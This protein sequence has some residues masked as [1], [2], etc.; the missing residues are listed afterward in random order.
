MV[1][2]IL[3][4][5]QIA[6][7][8]RQG[9][10]DQVEALKE[11][12]FIP[13]LS[14]ILVGNDGA[15]QSYVRSKKKAAE[16]I[17]MISEIVHLEETATEE[18]VLNELNRLNNDDSVSG[19]LVQVPLPKQVSE[20]KIL[21]AINPEK[22]VDGF[23][24]INIGKLYIDEQT[25]VPCT[26]LGIMEILKHADIDLE[27]KN[28][29]VIGRSHIVGQPV[30]KLLLQKNASVTI[31]HS[32]SKDMASYLKD[33]DVI[34]S[35]VGKPSLVT[36]DVVKEGAVIIDVG[37]TPDENGKLKGDVDY[38]AVKEIAG[39]ITPVPGGV[40][41]LTIT[42]VLNNTLLAEKMRRGIDS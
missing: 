23:H 26:P 35:A 25:F 13:K 4:G 14:V 15:S 6:K 31:L 34:V 24:P 29:V 7:D 20:Q 30:S 33:A 12:G 41:P 17:G 42:M 40:G 5:K 3:D 9:L 10:Q 37:N 8:Y 27:A 39:A 32:R 16:K 19:I 21:E 36:K 22:D 11:K 28:A 18:E 1:A 2:K 38:D